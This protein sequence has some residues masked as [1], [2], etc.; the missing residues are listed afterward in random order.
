MKKRKYTTD[1]LD[2]FPEVRK[3]LQKLRDESISDIERLDKQ[4]DFLANALGEVCNEVNA[5]LKALENPP[6]KK[7]V[8]K[9][10]PKTKKKPAKKKR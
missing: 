1:E 2:S 6:K 9:L 4:D 8:S 5:R 3:E 7:K 10:P